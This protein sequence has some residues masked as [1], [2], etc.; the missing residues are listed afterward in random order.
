[1][2]ELLQYIQSRELIHLRSEDEFIILDDFKY[3][4]TSYVQYCMNDISTTNAEPR[5]QYCTTTTV[6]RSQCHMTTDVSWFSI[7]QFKPDHCALTFL[8]NILYEYSGSSPPKEEFASYGI[9]YSENTCKKKMWDTTVMQSQFTMNI[10][11]KR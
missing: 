9:L 7:L 1:M 8:A 10:A 11:G 2:V 4:N 5:M 6:Q 3:N